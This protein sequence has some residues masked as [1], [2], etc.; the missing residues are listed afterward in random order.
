LPVAGVTK[1]EVVFP[2]QGLG[3]RRKHSWSQKRRRAAV[4]GREG[5]GQSGEN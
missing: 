5:E 3:D 2:V 1:K 4:G